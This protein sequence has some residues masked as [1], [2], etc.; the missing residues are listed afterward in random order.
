MP[1]SGSVRRKVMLKGLVIFADCVG[2]YFFSGALFLLGC[3]VLLPLAQHSQTIAAVFA[4]V[5][6][7]IAPII[8]K[9]HAGCGLLP[10]L[11]GALGIS[12]SKMA[13]NIKIVH[14]INNQPFVHFL[15]AVFKRRL[16]RKFFPWF[17][18]LESLPEFFK[19]FEGVNS[20]FLQFE[21][22]AGGIGGTFRCRFVGFDRAALILAGRK[23]QNGHAGGKGKD[24]TFLADMDQT[25][26]AL[27]KT[28]L[29]INRANLISTLGLVMSKLLQRTFPLT[30]D[31][32]H[33]STAKRL[34]Y[35]TWLDLSALCKVVSLLLGRAI[36]D[37]NDLSNLSHERAFGKRDDASDIFFDE[38]TADLR[39]ASRGIFHTG[40][41]VSD[42][43]TV[44]GGWL[45][46]DTSG[47]CQHLENA[48]RESLAAGHEA[49]ALEY[50]KREL[51]INEAVNGYDSPVAER[52][53]QAL[54][55]LRP[56]Q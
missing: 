26:A 45:G 1:E 32:V 50:L 37:G 20:R 8:Y 9:G 30:T 16:D 36:M 25:G 17:L 51:V 48:C 2:H 49:A 31:W 35:C 13:D 21:V 5:F 42:G 22:F 34:C 4:A 44:L 28:R 7:D 53:R 55:N 38:V 41:R 47:H 23:V 3:L 19:V 54:T 33:D 43:L 10:G 40:A 12:G 14:L 39:R 29:G 56:G 52:V 24:Q 15:L 18:I 46:F 11:Q 6:I 27:T